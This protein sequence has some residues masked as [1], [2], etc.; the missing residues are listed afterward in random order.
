MI[1]NIIISKTLIVREFKNTLGRILSNHLPPITTV[2]DAVGHQYG[3]VFR[4][5]IR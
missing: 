1:C 4:L 3:L 5:G 2:S